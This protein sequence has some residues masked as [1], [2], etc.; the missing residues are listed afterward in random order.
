MKENEM[1]KLVEEI[2]E[3]LAD[4]YIG[5]TVD[6]LQFCIPFHED[7]EFAEWAIARIRKAVQDGEIPLGAI[8]HAALRP[9]KE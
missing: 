4:Y 5:D 2:C 3:R 9:E 7:R 8:L 1:E 6:G